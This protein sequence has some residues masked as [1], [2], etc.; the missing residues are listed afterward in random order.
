M[1]EDFFVCGSQITYWKKMKAAIV[2]AF[3][4]F[5]KT[6]A[7]VREKWRNLDK[8]YRAKKKAATQTGAGKI[9]WPFFNQ[10]EAEMGDR[11]D[12]T[13]EGMTNIGG[14]NDTTVLRDF[15]DY[16][17]NDSSQVWP[18]DKADSADRDGSAKVR[19]KKKVKTGKDEVLVRFDQLLSSTDEAMKTLTKLAD[20]QE[21]LVEQNKQSVVASQEIADSRKKAADS[22]ATFASL[23]QNR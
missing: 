4:D 20:N 21:K 8:N 12:I 6:A 2:E 9:T 7:Q 23:L 3:S 15:G 22:F 17:M 11:N 14:E 13:L 19:G 18:T 16:E 1:K 10:I 5:D